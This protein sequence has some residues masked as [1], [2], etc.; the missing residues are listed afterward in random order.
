MPR[1]SV[2][3]FSLLSHSSL[4]NFEGE[5]LL[6]LLIWEKIQQTKRV[7]ERCTQICSMHVLQ[8]PPFFFC[9]FSYLTGLTSY[10]L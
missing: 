2:R 1:F 9:C 10:L 4:F 3:N 6:I 7:L 8:P 5:L